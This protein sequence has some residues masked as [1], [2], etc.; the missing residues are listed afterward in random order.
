MKTKKAFLF[1]LLVYF[2]SNLHAQGKMIE[3]S[4]KSAK[5]STELNTIA[6]AN[7][8]VNDKVGEAIDNLFNHDR[9]KKKSKKD[10]TTAEPDIFIAGPGKSIFTVSNCDYNSLNGLIGILKANENVKDIDDSFSNGAGTLK[11]S[12]SGK[13]NEILQDLISKSKIKLEVV[14]KDGSKIDLQ[15]K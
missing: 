15:V 8:K 9:S 11:I 3:N 4:L 14:S 2:S 12:H 7:K 6:K 13:C 10:D 1:A 5:D